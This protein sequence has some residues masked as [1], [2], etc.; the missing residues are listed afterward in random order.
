M[1]KK[2]ELLKMA[3]IIMIVFAAAAIVIS[4]INVYAGAQSLNVET[5]DTE[6]RQMLEESLQGTE[7]TIEEA[8]QT[9]AN[10]M[11]VVFIGTIFF[12]AVK[13]V[14]GVLGL[15]KCGTDNPKFFKGWGL[16][17]LLIGI[18]SI[19]GG[20]NPLAICNLIAGIIAPL[21]YVLVASRR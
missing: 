12:N 6:T 18:M 15:K 9:L 11:Y 17:F 1:D 2:K 16:F 8:V 7:T 13:I 19:S 4:V 10:T 14:V 21:F 20:I 3:S 5:M